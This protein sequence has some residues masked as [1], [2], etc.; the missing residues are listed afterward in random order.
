MTPTMNAATIVLNSV[1]GLIPNFISRIEKMI[2]I[3]AEKRYDISVAI[4]APN[5]P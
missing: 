5:I 3:I 1:V 4:A 2:I